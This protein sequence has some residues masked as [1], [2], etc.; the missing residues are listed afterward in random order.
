MAVVMMFGIQTCL[1]DDQINRSSF[2]KGFVF[3]T[4]SSAYQYEGAVNEDG[5]GKTIW[6]T[7]SQTFGKILDFSNGDVAVDHYHRYKVD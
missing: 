2:P 6:D 1:S 4:A 3:G 5:R 7:F